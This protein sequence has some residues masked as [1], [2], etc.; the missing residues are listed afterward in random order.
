MLPNALRWFWQAAL[1]CLCACALAWAPA[2]AQQVPRYA[3]SLDWNGRHYF[4]TLDNDGRNPEKWDFTLSVVTRPNSQ[5]PPESNKVFSTE[6]LLQVAGQRI[7][8][9]RLY[10]A[11]PLD[12]AWAVSRSEF[13][14]VEFQWTGGRVAYIAQGRKM[15]SPVFRRELPPADQVGRFDVGRLDVADGVKL[16]VGQF[17]RQYEALFRFP[18]AAPLPA[19]E[20]GQLVQGLVEV[21]GQQYNYEVR[22]SFF[23]PGDDNLSIRK[24]GQGLVYNTLMKV[25]EADSAQ[26]V[27]IDIHHVQLSGLSWLVFAN[28]LWRGRFDLKTGQINWQ[29]FGTDMQPAPDPPAPQPTF[30][31]QPG[32]RP[33]LEV[34]IKIAVENLIV[35]YHP[36]FVR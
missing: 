28:D 29:K 13:F 14:E 9:L 2:W 4:Y 36:A 1:A 21:Q 31:V 7:T 11:T 15:G 35:Q 33:P 24:P 19:R 34:L 26:T 17:V 20:A 27:T 8:H 18:G 10:G 32:G 30:V 3:A 23:N 25:A 6:A 5:A 12:Y 16:A 22:R